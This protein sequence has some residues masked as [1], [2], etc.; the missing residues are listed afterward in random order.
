MPLLSAKDDIFRY[1]TGKISRRF[2]GLGFKPSANAVAEE[3]NP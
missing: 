2:E 1:I 3:E